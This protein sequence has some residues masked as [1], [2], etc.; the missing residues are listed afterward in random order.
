M[1]HVSSHMLI[2]VAILG[3]EKALIDN[4]MIQSK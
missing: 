1:H 4:D 3:A 2:Q